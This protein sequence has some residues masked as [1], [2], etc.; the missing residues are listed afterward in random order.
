MMSY[1]AVLCLC[2]LATV[3]STNKELLSA[4]R[5]GNAELAQRLLSSGSLD[6]SELWFF[7]NSYEIYY[8]YDAH[9]TLLHAAALWG[10]SD[11]LHVLL[12]AWPA[13]AQARD[14]EGSLPLHV[15]CGYSRSQNNCINGS[16]AVVQTLLQQWPESVKVADREGFL[17][18]HRAS[19]G[20]S[21]S[22][23]SDVPLVQLLLE[24][25]PESVKA[26]NNQ[27]KLPL[28]LAACCNSLELVQLLLQQWPDSVKAVD[29]QGA[30]PLHLAACCNSLDL[31]QLLLQQWPDSVKAVDNHGS[32]P[33]HHAACCNSLELVQLLLQHWRQR[34]HV[35]LNDG[36]TLL[37][38]AGQGDSNSSVQKARWI[39]QISPPP[40]YT[41]NLDC[42]VLIELACNTTEASQSWK[43]AARELK[44]HHAEHQSAE[45]LQLWLDYCGG[46]PNYRDSTG[47]RLID[48]LWSSEAQD[49]QM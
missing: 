8:E 13:G 47:S 9:T 32:L 44:C 37:G 14:S 49:E 41:P 33:L 15:A 45:N 11:V 19:R 36:L 42:R 17:L 6:T 35:V 4:V 5:S 1:R 24:R 31:V 22:S 27:G 23:G 34:F 10:F 29:N 20:S 12:T 39:F 25:W 38:A 2:S 40:S 46:S 16:L 43:D 48:L 18:L 3:A 26:V 7:D 30:L 21:P 28:H